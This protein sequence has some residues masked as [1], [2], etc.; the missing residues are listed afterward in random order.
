MGFPG[1]QLPG[2]V[3]G[4]KYKRKLTMSGGFSTFPTYL[5]LL[6]TLL[7]LDCSTNDLQRR[8][9]TS[10]DWIRIFGGSR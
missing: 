1:G 9:R 7:S 4:P 8:T 5:V 10:A 2:D 6:T 3:E